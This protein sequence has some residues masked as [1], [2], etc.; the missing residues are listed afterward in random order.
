MVLTAGF[1]FAANGTVSKVIL[2]SGL[3]SLRLTEARCLGA[4]VGLAAIL[5]AFRR[6]TLRA[7]RRELFFLAVFGVIG[8]ALVQLLYFLAIERLD[9]GVSLVIQYLGPLLVAL[10]ARFVLKEHVRPRIWVALVLALTGLS[11]VVDLWRGVSLDGWGVTFSLLSAATFAAYLLMA[12]RIVGDGRDTLSLLC[13]GFFFASVFWAIAQPWWRFPGDIPGR[14]ISLLGNLAGVDLPVW[15]LMLWMV[16]LGT[17]VPFILIV[18]AL[19][20]LPATRVGL[21][22]MIEPVVATVIALAWLDETLSAQQVA[23][24]AVVLAGILLAH[25][26]R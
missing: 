18:G 1:L 24:G 26:A 7:D 9:I 6:D 8:V 11:L 14:D 16:V 10:W 25:T 2:S 21:I 3:G 17:I 15:T 23:G 4:L 13:Y 19:R 12:E 5:L 20:H 22:A